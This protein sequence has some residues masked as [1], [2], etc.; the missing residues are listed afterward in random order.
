MLQQH[1]L[2]RRCT[3]IFRVLCV[4]K[5]K[6]PGR[7]ITASVTPDHNRDPAPKEASQLELRPELVP[8]IRDALLDKRLL[9][10]K[11]KYQRSHGGITQ[12]LRIIRS[13]QELLQAIQE[14]VVSHE[15]GL[16][17]CSVYPDLIRALERC[18]HQCT[19]NEALRDV[20]AIIARLKCLGV[21]LP[22]Q[23]LNFFMVGAV[24]RGSPAALMAYISMIKSRNE[25]KSRRWVPLTNLLTQF[26]NQEP[27]QRTFQGW[28]GKRKRQE[29]LC[30]IQVLLSEWDEMLESQQDGTGSHDNEISNTNLNNFVQAF[31]SLGGSKL[32]WQVAKTYYHRY[33][34]LH[35]K[36]WTSLL[37]Y[38]DSIRGWLPALVRQYED[39]LQFLQR[40]TFKLLFAHPELIKEWTPDMTEPVKVA[41]ESH[42]IRIE[43]LM[44]IQWK[45]GENGFHERKL[46][47]QNNTRSPPST[48]TPVTLQAGSSADASF[49]IR[50]LKTKVVR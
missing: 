8:S 44:H 15:D 40:E 10:K 48:T 7:S 17:L 24:R 28:N 1:S 12:R 11:P 47:I 34:P 41:L 26:M 16:R 4:I 13:R 23:L 27:H 35:N 9:Q 36:T 31:L 38:P 21:A 6:T 22:E 3:H 46:D 42:L 45:G 29:W 50:N 43:R 20:N 5:S 33:G 49:I 14:N 18:W 32:A 25:E 37:D 39:Q 2:N 19:E 30:I